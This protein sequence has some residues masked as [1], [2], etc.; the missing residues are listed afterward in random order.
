MPK[1]IVHLPAG[2]QVFELAEDRPFV[3]GRAGDCSLVLDGQ[4]CSRAH[5]H[6]QKRD[7]AFVAK[8]LGS[9]NGTYVNG[10]RISE[11][12]LSPGDMVS[13]GGVQMYFEK[14]PAGQSPAAAEPVQK[15][16]VATTKI[17]TTRTCEACGETI[18]GAARTCPQCGE[19]QGELTLTPRCPICNGD[20]RHQG[21]YCVRCGA[22]LADGKAPVACIHCRTVVLDAMALCSQCGSDP[23]GLG[24]DGAAHGA[25]APG[26]KWA[27][28]VGVAGALAA[29]AFIGYTEYQKRQ[30]ARLALEAEEGAQRA[31]VRSSWREKHGQLVERSEGDEQEGASDETTSDETQTPN[32]PEVDASQSPSDGTATEE[33][34]TPPPVLQEDTSPAAP[35]TPAGEAV[36]PLAPP[37]GEKGAADKPASGSD[38]APPEVPGDAGPEQ[39]AKRDAEPPPQGEAEQ[40]PP[41]AGKDK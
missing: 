27:I 8:D 5:C 29:A 26:T 12:A 22:G 30:R 38:A 11:V 21:T 9:R 2:K 16:P 23:F 39:P 34:A 36:A 6:L 7:D 35:A 37:V 13:V 14:E 32:L 40:K 10:Q 1:L 17:E 24:E 20:Q 19:M 31:E 28:I 33:S 41:A 4:R 25:M 15:R 18:P 3:I